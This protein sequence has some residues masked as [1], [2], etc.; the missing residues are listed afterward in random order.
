VVVDE[1]GAF[2]GTVLGHQVLA[3]IESAARPPAPDRDLA[4]R[5]AT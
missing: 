4:G 1:T 5:S 3:A 2:A